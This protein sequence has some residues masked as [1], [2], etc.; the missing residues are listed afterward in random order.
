[1]DKVIILTDG[2]TSDAHNPNLFQKRFFMGLGK[3]VDTASLSLMCRLPTPADYKEVTLF[4]FEV[5]GLNVVSSKLDDYIQSMSGVI[6]LCQLSKMNKSVV[7]RIYNV[8]Q[9]CKPNPLLICIGVDDMESQDKINKVSKI[10]A[11][12]NSSTSMVTFVDNIGGDDQVKKAKVWYYD[13]MS[14]HKINKTVGT[15]GIT[16]YIPPQSKHKLVH[17]IRTVED[18]WLTNINTHTMM[19][20]SDLVKQFE[21]N[22]LP[23]SKWNHYSRLKIVYYALKIYGYSNAIDQKGWLCTNWINYKSSVGHGH[24]W[25]YTLTRFWINVIYGVMTKH[26]YENFDDMYKSNVFLSNGKLFKDFYTDDVVFSQNART[27]WIKP[28]ILPKHGS[29]TRRT[30]TYV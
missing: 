27:N 14:N 16:V 23:L 5:F 17:T 4:T 15:N 9:L 6:I 28:N 24:L 25:N 1:M 8:R 12:L 10:F 2:D 26:K 7:K 21:S 30:V 18:C 19:Q 20:M 11:K 13:T 3:H 22:T 29:F